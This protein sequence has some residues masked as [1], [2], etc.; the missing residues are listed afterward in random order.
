[1]FLGSYFWGCLADIEGR[2]YALLRALFSHGILELISSFIPYYWG[3]VVLKFLSGV[4]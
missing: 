2:K 3:Y 4:T 1:M